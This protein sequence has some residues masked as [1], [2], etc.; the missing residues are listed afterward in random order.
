MRNSTLGA[1]PQELQ[2]EHQILQTAAEAPE[3]LLRSSNQQSTGV[4]RSTGLLLTK[5]QIISVRKYEMAARALPDTLERVDAYLRFGSANGG[6]AGLTTNDF[7]QTFSK[8]RQHGQKWNPLELRIKLVTTQLNIFSGE[9]NI[10]A[11]D[12]MSIYERIENQKDP[13]VLAVETLADLK[14]LELGKGVLSGIALSA[15]DKRR[16]RSFGVYLKD[17]LDNIKDLRDKA[18]QIKVDLENFSRELAENVLPDIQL[19]VRFIDNNTLSAEIKTL[20]ESI[21]ARSRA[22]DD[23]TKE[24]K[25]GVERSLSTAFGS[26]PGL[27]MAIYIGV[28]AD[29]IRIERNKL[30]KAQEA[31]IEQ[32]R[33]KDQ[34]LASLLRIRNDLQNFTAIAIDADVATKNLVFT[35]NSLYLYIDRSMTQ[36]A[37][38][39]DALELDIFMQRFRLVARPW[40]NIENESAA[41]NNVFKEADDE[42]RLGNPGATL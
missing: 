26:L 13:S 5:D 37:R 21:E 24:Y 19:R 6:G 27:A 20:K 7:L 14:A 31:E 10:Y 8:T 40:K 9:M 12:I 39:D 29:K 32:V 23:K 30:N 38:I 28:E 35:W 36:S 25:A 33:Q 4:L 3:I 34:T 42:I 11:E 22:I 2:Q 16:I 41:L 18:E 17:I 1:T 15:T